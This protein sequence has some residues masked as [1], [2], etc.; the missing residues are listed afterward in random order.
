MNQ[1]IYYIP[2]NYTDAGRLFGFFEVRNAIE[3][4]LLGVP[5]LFFCIYCLHF[6][7]STKIFVTIF[8][9]VP[10]VGFAL[11]GLRDDS[12]TRFLRCLFQ[13]RRGRRAITFRGEVYQREF[14][15]SHLW[16]SRT[17]KQ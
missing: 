10:L 7:L 2:A 12:L 16:R 3:A 8:L 6:E 1:S 4:V 14:E 17:G 5:T 11:I 15:K 9:T 13:W